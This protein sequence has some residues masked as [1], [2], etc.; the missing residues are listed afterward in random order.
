MISAKTRSAAK[1][2][3]GSDNR[4]DLYRK[5]LRR[6]TG[7]HK[8]V[9]RTA[10]KTILNASVLWVAD[11]ERSVSCFKRFRNGDGGGIQSIYSRQRSCNFLKDEWAR[12]CRI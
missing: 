11:R 9:D 6:E 5:V 10:T 8:S 3:A 1:F 4:Q 12:Y 7:T 2:G